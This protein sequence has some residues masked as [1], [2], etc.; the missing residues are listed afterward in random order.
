[1]S[2]FILNNKVQTVH[3]DM[4]GSQYTFA[5]DY[6]ALSMPHARSSELCH[7]FRYTVFKTDFFLN[8]AVRQYFSFLI[9]LLRMNT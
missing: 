1:M 5:R 4:S 7:G 2:G 9:N 6:S 3:S 8:Q